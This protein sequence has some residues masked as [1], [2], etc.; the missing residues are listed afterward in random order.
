MKYILKKESPEEF[1]IWKSR[2]NPK[3]WKWQDLKGKRAKD[4]PHGICDYSKEELRQALLEE[5]HYTCAYCECSI[6]YNTTYLRIDHVE[7]RNGDINKDRIFDYL[8][9]VL[10][11]KGY[12]LENE[13]GL[14]AILTCDQAKAN[15]PIP[16]SP[17]QVDCS[18]NFLFTESGHIHGENSKANE[19]IKVLNLNN[20]KLRNQ[21]KAS[22]EG[23][24]FDDLD[25]EF[26]LSEEQYK[27][28]LASLSP[29]Q[30]YKTAIIQVL[31]AYT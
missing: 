20:A 2:L 31:T 19:T 23:F 9:L 4:L 3:T 28:L 18:S 12:Y 24:L 11:C 13:L 7:P 29:N 16:I 15:K 10:S 27:S 14:P 22:V 21:R 30:A 25:G 5:Q 8:N 17:L 6:P 26:Y 1:E